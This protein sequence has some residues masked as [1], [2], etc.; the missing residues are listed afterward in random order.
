LLDAQDWLDVSA[1][2][3]GGEAAALLAESGFPL[4]KVLSAPCAALA[5]ACSDAFGRPPLLEA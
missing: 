1:G 3:S 2:L 4:P 5:R